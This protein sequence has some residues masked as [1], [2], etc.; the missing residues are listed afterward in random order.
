[1]PGRNGTGP[2]GSGPMTGRGF[3]NCTGNGLRSKPRLG[4]GLGFGG[5][6]CF[7]NGYYWQAN[8]FMRLNVNQNSKE[9]LVEQKRILE[10]RLNLVNQDLKSIEKENKNEP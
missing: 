9:T 4:L 1:M 6:R 3:G 5:R 8:S 10:E 2:V 7:G